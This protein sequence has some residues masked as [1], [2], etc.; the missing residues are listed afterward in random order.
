M[1]WVAEELGI[2]AGINYRTADL[3]RPSPSELRNGRRL[4]RQRRWAM[5]DAVLGRVHDARSGGAVRGHLVYNDQGRPPGPPDYLNLIARRGG[6]WKASSPSTTDD[7]RSRSPSWRWWMG[8]AATW[9]GAS[10]SSKASSVRP[11]PSTRCSPATT[12]ARSS[13]R[14]AQRRQT[15][16]KANPTTTP[17][18]R[19]RLSTS[20][21]KAVRSYSH[22]AHGN[23]PRAP[24]ASATRSR[25]RTKAASRRG[26]LSASARVHTLMNTLSMRSCNRAAT[27]SLSQ[28]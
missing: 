14:S 2:D 21:V 5:L 28:A 16:T 9:C 6:G 20:S 24:M 19:G 15:H 4:L 23:R 22:R 18:A 17:V 27:K 13:S 25:A 10:T 12:S 11:R 26:V 7:S 8:R 3:P 1:R